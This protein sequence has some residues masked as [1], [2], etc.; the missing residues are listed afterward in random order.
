MNRKYNLITLLLIPFLTLLI[1]SCGGTKDESSQDSSDEFKAAEEEVKSQIESVM[2]DI[3]SP[4][5][6]PGLLMRT[7]VEYNQALLHSNANI[8]KYMTGNDKTA[9]NLGVYSTDVGY[10][11]SYDKVQDALNYMTTSKRMADELGLSG[12]F[13]NSMIA[14][15]ESNL[16][17]KDS[18]AI[19]LNGAINNSRDFLRNENRTRLAALLLTGSL[20]EGLYISCEL[21]KNYPKDILPE[22]QRNMVL[23]D[24]I[25]IILE[26]QKSTGEIVKMLS[27]ID[28]SAPVE[29]LTKEYTALEAA[30]AT[31]NIEDKISNND[32]SLIL[33]D[34]SL[35]E[36]TTIV[37]RI[38]KGIIE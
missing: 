26:Q 4:S 21:I 3:P 11:I 36:I 14:Q 1:T 23:M 20:T 17:N 22:E 13:E 28:Q 24:L 7:G 10:L 12:T 15:F 30:F 35:I 38:R 27:S 18:L 5:E 6:I 16:S 31:L 29:N 2:Y 33:T 37:E 8:D 25:R 9:L 32:G 34:A 19:L